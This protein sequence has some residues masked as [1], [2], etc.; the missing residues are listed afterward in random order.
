M[1]VKSITNSTENINW[2]RKYKLPSNA[3]NWAEVYPNTSV[4]AYQCTWVKCIVTSGQITLYWEFNLSRKYLAVS[5]RNNW[6]HVLV[7]INE[8]TV[9]DVF[10]AH[11]IVSYDTIFF[12]FICSLFTNRQLCSKEPARDLKVWFRIGFRNT[13]PR[14]IWRDTPVNSPLDNNYYF[15]SISSS[16]ASS[17]GCSS[18]GKRESELGPIKGKIN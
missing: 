5:N 6:K 8:L 10:P 17:R 4:R 16:R 9:E 15:A 1:P 7:R 12:N 11:Y 3:K 14:D 2:G 18:R 13:W